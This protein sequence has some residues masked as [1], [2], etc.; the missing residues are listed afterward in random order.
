M[1]GSKLD[2]LIL[3]PGRAELEM[4][5]ARNEEFDLKTGTKLIS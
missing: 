2:L 3:G 1:G 4:F 5:R